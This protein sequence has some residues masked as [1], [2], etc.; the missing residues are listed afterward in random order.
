M[1][2]ELCPPLNKR[3]NLG[4]RHVDHTLSSVKNSGP[5]GSAGTRYFFFFLQNTQVHG[6]HK[7]TVKGM[8]MRGRCLVLRS[9]SCMLSLQG[10]LRTVGCGPGTRKGLLQG[11]SRVILNMLSFHALRQVP[12]VCVPLQPVAPTSPSRDLTCAI[13]TT[14]SHPSP[15]V[16]YAVPTTL[17]IHRAIDA[18]NVRPGT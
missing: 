9:T 10:N 8:R 1:P 12:K 2:L 16:C 18:A 14:A 5:K 17:P 13:G 7:N 4:G 3:G 11:I 6:F 15:Q